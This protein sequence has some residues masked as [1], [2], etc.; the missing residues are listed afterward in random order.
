MQ[1]ATAQA[2]HSCDLMQLLTEEEHPHW[3]AFLLQADNA[4]LFHS[5]WWYRAWGIKPVVHV[6]R[7]NTGAIT[8]G[9]CF[10][11]DRR[12]GAPAL[13]PPPMTP[14]NC[15]VLSP[16]V[17]LARHAR[18]TR[19]KNVLLGALHSLPPLGVYDFSFGPRPTAP[20][21]LPFVWNGFETVVR[22]TYRIPFSESETW[23]QHA[24]QT[25]RWQL[26]KTRKELQAAGYSIQ[27]DASF[28]DVLP[29]LQQTASFKG[30]TLRSVAGRM[31]A[32]WAAVLARGAGRTYVLYDADQR[33]LSATLM[34]WDNR[35]CFY[36]A[37]GIRVDI[38]KASFSNVM[39][40]EAMIRDAHTMGLD[41]DF[42]GSSLPGV[43]CF[44]RSF[45]GLLCPTYRVIRCRSPL[46][47]LVGYFARSYTALRER[48]WVWHE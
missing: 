27:R 44:F 17:K 14:M 9:F 46:P 45:G 34:V 36:L 16:P 7:D 23:Q 35:S 28:A 40:V 38:R 26:R 39:L 5:T 12:W 19:E 47:A 13:V 25:Q 15:P 22:Y 29:L 42:E 41:F 11:T 18:Y 20:N 3:D 37:G 10:A 1:Q 6:L 21:L 2:Q 33:P 31:P 8:A 32:W 43:E 4:S 24:S 48:K 30:F